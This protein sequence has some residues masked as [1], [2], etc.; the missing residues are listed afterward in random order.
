M[1]MTEDM[2]D[3]FSWGF[4]V[5]DHLM[6]S[7]RWRVFGRRLASKKSGKQPVVH[8][9]QDSRAIESSLEEGGGEDQDFFMGPV[10]LGER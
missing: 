8:N 3:R 9:D 7:V 2:E 10:K 5:S 4:V 6:N 1:V